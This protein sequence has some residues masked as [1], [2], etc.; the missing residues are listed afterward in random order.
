[1]F[2]DTQLPARL[3]PPPTYRLREE[4][5]HVSANTASLQKAEHD[6]TPLASPLQLL[7]S[8]RPMPPACTPPAVL[9]DPPAYR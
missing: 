1:M 8:H 2:C 7:P 9:N 5:S 3:N 6:E 4:L